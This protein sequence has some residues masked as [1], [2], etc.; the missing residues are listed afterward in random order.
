MK[1]ILGLVLENLL[2]SL[3]AFLRGLVADRQTRADN[4]DLGA[5][6][7]ETATDRVIDAMEVEQDAVDGMDRAGAGGVLD[8]LR[9]HGDGTAGADR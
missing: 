4:M 1:T 6:R 2:A 3:V 9:R 5:K 8:R 7:A